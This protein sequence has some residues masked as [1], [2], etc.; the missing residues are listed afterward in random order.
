[1]VVT[2]FCS[3]ILIVGSRSLAGTLEQ[4]HGLV[5]EP[6]GRREETGVRP[7]LRE[8]TRH[9]GRSFV[10]QPLQVMAVDVS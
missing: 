5:A 8:A 1:L 9:L 3:V 4:A 6:S 7:V 2:S 10:H